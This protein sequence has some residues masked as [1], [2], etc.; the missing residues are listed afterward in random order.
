L[1]CFAARLP[2]PLSDGAA[3]DLRFFERKLEVIE[4]NDAAFV[5]LE[6]IKT[7]LSK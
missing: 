4:D 5:A 3:A 6:A 7:R 1:F 2:A